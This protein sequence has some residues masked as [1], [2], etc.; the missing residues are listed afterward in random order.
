MSTRTMLFRTNRSQAVRL[1]REV[2]FPAEVRE[3]AIV[4]DGDRRIVMPADRQWDDFFAAPGIDLPAR[5]QPAMQKRE[6]L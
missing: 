5:E 6:T 1:P 4:K 2:A 3:V